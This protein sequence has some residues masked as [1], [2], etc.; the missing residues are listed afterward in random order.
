MTVPVL[1]YGKLQVEYGFVDDAGNAIAG[2]LDLGEPVPGTPS[3]PVAV[4]LKRTQ[5]MYNRGP[6]IPSFGPDGDLL[7]FFELE[8][9]NWPILAETE[10]SLVATTFQRSV[11]SGTS[12][13]GWEA[14]S[15]D[16]IEI[17]TDDGETWVPASSDLSAD[18]LSLFTTTSP[19]LV[20]GKVGD[21]GSYYYWHYPELPAEQTAEILVRLNIPEGAATNGDFRAHLEV[22][23]R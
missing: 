14:V 18:I 21:I 6:Y 7:Y 9:Y 17:S 11:S 19:D 12:A 2:V 3:T 8:R 20:Y 15:E 10:L 4:T 1:P 22:F 16:W 5:S 23:V 13:D